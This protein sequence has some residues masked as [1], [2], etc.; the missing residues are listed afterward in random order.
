M[1]AWHQDVVLGKEEA[2]SLVKVIES[3]NKRWE[4]ELEMK[5][6]KAS[7]KWKGANRMT[8]E[9]DEAIDNNIL[10]RNEEA[11]S[12]SILGQRQERKRQIKFSMKAA[13]QLI[14]ENSDSH[15]VVYFCRNVGSTFLIF[16]PP[17]TKP[18]SEIIV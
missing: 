8:L 11:L 13:K 17:C 7:Q 15:Y 10:D 9:E 3:T 6:R 12:V 2:E 18:S 5:R 14:G 4:G 1:D 16:S